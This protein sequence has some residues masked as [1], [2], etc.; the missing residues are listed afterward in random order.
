MLWAM[1]AIYYF[2]ASKTEEGLRQRVFKGNSRI[3]ADIKH[4][5]SALIGVRNRER[6]NSLS[7]EEKCELSKKISDGVKRANNERGC[8]WNGKHHSEKTKNLL[9]TVKKNTGVGKDNSQYGSFWGMNA[10]TFE[11]RKFK[12]GEELPDG[13]I[14]GRCQ[15]SKRR[16][17]RDK[18]QKSKR[19]LRKKDNQEKIDLYTKMYEDYCKIPFSE[20]VKKYNYQYS[21][22]N[23]V[24]MCKKYV[25]DFIPQN[26]KRR[27]S[28]SK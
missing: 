25:K 17:E 18:D 28:S 13:W 20:V 3:Y 24:Q 7:C 23:F 4:K 22:A 11:S 15:N 1:G 9:S 16:L 10:E 5:L 19:K 26:G 12:K 14:R 8:W 27:I 2:P 21:L 6:I